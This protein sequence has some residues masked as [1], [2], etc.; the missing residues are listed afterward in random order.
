M[1]RK[2]QDARPEGHDGFVTFIPW[3]FM[4]RGTKL[5]EKTAYAAGSPPQNI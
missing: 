1:L 2:L 5:A 3:P 4:D